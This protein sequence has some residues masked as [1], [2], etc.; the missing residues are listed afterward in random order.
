MRRIGTGFVGLMP[1]PDAEEDLREGMEQLRHQGATLLVS[2]LEPQETEALNLNGEAAAVRQSGMEFLSH[3][4]P[5]RGLPADSD[6][7]CS[8]V[9]M[10]NDRVIQGG[11]VVA[12][13]WGG[14]GRS[15]LLV[16]SVLTAMG[17]GPKD[18]F[19]EVSRAR[20]ERVPE[21]SAQEAWLH[22][23]TPRIRHGG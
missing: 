16:A 3:P 13:C 10:L 21:T 6:A 4:I 22:Q 15:G 18:A 20:G 7:F 19:E 12:H 17:S 2:L 11:G 9:E 5:D 23:H 1:R 14:I 8:L